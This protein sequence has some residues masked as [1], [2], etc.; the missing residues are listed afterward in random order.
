MRVIG[1]IDIRNGRAVHARA[2]ERA[3]YRPVTRFAG[4]AIE[5]GDAEALAGHYMQRGVRELYVA[6]LDA[7][8]GGPFDAGSLA[9][10]AALGSPLWVDAGVADATQAGAV[11]TAG[12]ARVVVGLETLLG[13]EGLTDVQRVAGSG[14]LTFSLDLRHGAPLVAPTAR[15]PQSV[16]CPVDFARLAADR[17]AD[18]IIVLDLARV[19]M[20]TGL[21]LALLDAV[22]R[23][24]PDVLLL[25]GGG[26]GGAEDLASLSAAGCDGVLVASALHDGRITAEDVHIAYGT[27][28]TSRPRT[29]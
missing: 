19:G 9:R 17:G 13:P 11:L 1:V 10:L 28:R 25:A 16:V 14:R 5:P 24:V 6:V 21:D 3:H 7:I 15:W 8:E 18:A 12:A 26:V 29:M 4:I 2:G 27:E 20:G 22:R 23:A